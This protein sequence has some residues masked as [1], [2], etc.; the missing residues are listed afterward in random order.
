MYD[1]PVARNLWPLSIRSVRKKGYQKLKP[2]IFVHGA[3]CGNWVWENLLR[4]FGDQEYEYHFAE[5]PFRNAAEDSQV[6]EANFNLYRDSVYEVVRRVE[7]TTGQKPIM[8]GH[9]LGGV[10]VQSLASLGVV[11]RAVLIAPACPGGV[12]QIT[13]KMLQV[14]SWWITR[15]GFWK[16]STKMPFEHFHRYLLN[17]WDKN[18]AE[19]FYSRLVRDSGRVLAQIAFWHSSTFV[20]AEA[21]AC[22]VL[23]LAG[24][25]DQITTPSMVKFLADRYRGR[26]IEYDASHFLFQ[27]KKHLPRVAHDILSFIAEG[28]DQAANPLQGVA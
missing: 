3:W 18:E 28:K 26:Y 4:E 25:R 22:P 19:L 21:V 20:P 13:P 8:I 23:C 16:T 6:S 17:G 5:L 12:F 14:F 11:E 1:A 2:I 10:I 7:A 9:S 27:E 24:S 15:W